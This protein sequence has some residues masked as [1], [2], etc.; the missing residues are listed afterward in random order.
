ME[1]DYPKFSKSG[2]W[3]VIRRAS[4]HGRTLTDLQKTNY[5]HG[6][7]LSICAPFMT[8]HKGNDPLKSSGTYRWRPHLV[9]YRSGLPSAFGRGNAR[10]FCFVVNIKIY[11]FGKWGSTLRSLSLVDLGQCNSLLDVFSKWGSSPHVLFC[12]ILFNMFYRRYECTRFRGWPNYAE[13]VYLTQ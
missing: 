3:F 6:I 5:I 11:Q 13:S 8:L 9:T 10:Y 1:I 12:E 2:Y 7:Q 4:V